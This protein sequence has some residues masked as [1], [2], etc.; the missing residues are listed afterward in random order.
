MLGFLTGN[1]RWICWHGLHPPFEPSDR[2]HQRNLQ[3]DFRRS[4]EFL[5]LLQCSSICLQFQKWT[6]LVQTLFSEWLWII[7]GIEM[8]ICNSWWLQWQILQKKELNYW[9]SILKILTLPTLHTFA[10]KCI[11]VG[12]N[13]F[14]QVWIL[15]IFSN[16]IQN[17]KVIMGEEKLGNYG[18]LEKKH[19]PR[20]KSLLPRVGLLMFNW[21]RMRQITHNVARNHFRVRR[22]K[23][24]TYWATPVMSHKNA[25]F[26]AH[27]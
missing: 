12:F 14:F 26:F 20:H 19:V 21:L 2:L 6:K 15:H 9:R 5:E 17:W 24:I 11:F 16:A 1:P 10:P 27:A 3:S 22:T 13:N 4:V 8:H 25:L 18:A 23:S 7:E